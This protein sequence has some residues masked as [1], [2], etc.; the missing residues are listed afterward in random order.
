MNKNGDELKTIGLRFKAIMKKYFDS[1]ASVSSIRK[2]METGVSACS[3]LKE[4]Q[5]RAL[6]LAML[7]DPVTAERYYVMKDSLE[8][9]NTINNQ[10]EAFRNSLIGASNAVLPMEPSAVVDTQPQSLETSSVIHGNLSMPSLVSSPMQSEEEPSDIE[11]IH[12][13][14]NTVANTLVPIQKRARNQTKYPLKPGDWNCSF[15]DYTN[16]ARR[17][18]CNRCGKGKNKRS[19]YEIAP[20]NTQAKKPK[21]A[22]DISKVMKKS[23]NKQGKVI[24]KVVS[25]K[26]GTI[27]VSEKHVPVSL[28]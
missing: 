9:S 4:D 8:E 1:E 3:G 23:T 5:K 2:A 12:T 14:A 6:S 17:L 18:E 10:W 20:V 21:V 15:C 16:F 22:E 28:L 7:H 24:Y 11:N 25:Q 13:V 19:A 27:W 26:H